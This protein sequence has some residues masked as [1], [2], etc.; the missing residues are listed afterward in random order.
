MLGLLDCRF[1][2]R[3]KSMVDLSALSKMRPISAD[4]HVT[5][6]PGCYIDRIDPKYR[7]IAPRMIND[8]VKGATFLVEGIAPIGI[9]NAAA[10]G[11]LASELKKSEV[12]TF[13]KLHRGGWEA[14]SRLPAMDLDGVF[15]ELIYPT[16]GMALYSIPDPEYMAACM[17]AY[18]RWL[19]E[20]VGESP[21]RLFGIGQSPA[22]SPESLVADLKNIKAMGLKGVM[23]PLTPGFSDYDD[24]AYD[25]A[26]ETAI[27]LNLPLCFHVLT[28]SAK[29]SVMQQGVRGGKLANIMNIVRANQDVLGVFI[30][31][32]VFDRHPLLRMVCVEADAGWVPHYAFRMDHA[33]ERYADWLGSRTLQKL[34]SEVFFE[35]VFFTFQDDFV[36]FKSLDLLNPKR[37]LWASDYPHSDSTWPK[38]MEVLKTQTEG[39][40]PALVKSIVHDNVVELFDLELVD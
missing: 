37:L 7:D 21:D 15:A 38:S 17:E 14:E 20:F 32:G 18:N 3:E 2:E 6:P 12:R 31:G 34:P 11:I 23:M 16:V 19:R 39:L 1:K 10:A 5:E 30:F 22:L 25:E 24:P 29:G 36:A 13:D 4:S 26:W 8:P 27:G 9:G 35:N 33:Y 28:R 40:D